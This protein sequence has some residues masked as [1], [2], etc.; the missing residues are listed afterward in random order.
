[1]DTVVSIVTAARE[2]RIEKEKIARR[3]ERRR[4]VN[5][6]Y[7]ALAR[8]LLVNDPNFTG[9]HA[10]MYWNR[11]AIFS[12]QEDLY[13]LP[14][15]KALLENDTPS[16]GDEQW[17][18]VQEEVKCFAMIKRLRDARTLAELI[19]HGDLDEPIDELEAITSENL[20][21]VIAECSV[22]AEKLKLATAVFWCKTCST[23]LRY[24]EA[25][26]HEHA[27]TAGCLNYS[28]LPP[29]D[30]PVRALLMSVGLDPDTATKQD[31]DAVVGYGANQ[32]F[33]IECARCDERIRVTGT[34]S[35]IVSFLAAVS[36]GPATDVP[37]SS[38]TT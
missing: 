2:R 26:S 24:P 29:D 16:I 15:V 7:D 10:A 9:T 11:Q 30:S 22:I 5:Y 34:F 32:I 21:A 35:H 12:S 33:A 20:E 14:C 8:A 19:T 3:N 36:V 4:R 18:A 6:N 17:A 38:N 1:M 31:A 37:E 28:Y 23:L 27:R 25:L 13:E